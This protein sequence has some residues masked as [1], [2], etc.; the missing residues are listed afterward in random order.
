MKDDY[1]RCMFK[2]NPPHEGVAAKAA[3]VVETAEA[4]AVTDAH[5][6]AV[7]WQRRRRRRTGQCGSITV[8]EGVGQ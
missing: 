1:T 7:G 4:T 3:A 2:M 8:R 6:V 5:Q